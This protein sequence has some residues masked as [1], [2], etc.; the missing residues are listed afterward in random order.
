MMIKNADETS[1]IGVF[2]ASMHAYLVSRSKNRN[3]VAEF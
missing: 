3:F 2:N 1:F